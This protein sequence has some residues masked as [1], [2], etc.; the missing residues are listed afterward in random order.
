LATAQRA[1][2]GKRLLTYFVEPGL[3]CVEHGYLRRFIGN[4]VQGFDGGETDG[5][6]ITAVE[7]PLRAA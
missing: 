4:A 6:G 5:V 1:V 7:N 2:Q 3:E